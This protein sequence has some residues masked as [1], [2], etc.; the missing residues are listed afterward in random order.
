MTFRLVVLLAGAGTAAA[1][2]WPGWRGPAGMGH[3]AERALPLTWGGKD[4]ANVAW[5]VDLP[6]VAAKAGQDQNQSSPV[7]VGGKVFVTASYWP[8]GKADPKAFPEHHVACY[9][10]ADGKLLWDTKVPPGPWLL[11]DLRGGYTAPTPAADAER[12]YVVFGS[13]VVAAL[14]HAGRPVWRR[15]LTPH[16]FDVALAASPVL[17]DETLILQLDQ[18]GNESRLLALDRK[19]GEPRWEEKRPK[20]G[21]A[22]STPVVATVGGK[23]QLLVSASNAVQGVDPATGKVLWT[24][25]ARGDTVTPVLAG[26][27]VYADSGR[28]GPGLAVDPTGT[29]D[30]TKTHVKWKLPQVPE[31]YSSPVAVGEFLYRLHSPEVLRCVRAATGE[32]VFTERLPGV[33]TAC[34][35]VADAAGRVYCASAGKSYVL[36]AGPTP[37]VLAVNDLGDAGPASPAVADGALFLKG[38][39]WLVCVRAKD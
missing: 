30:V 27:L 21:F 4:G 37:E 17:F 22:H 15:E 13:A 14:D 7:V 39:R 5:K 23:Q 1:A 31:G 8:G 28:G 2:D 33:Q 16:K 10:A 36:K 6:G 29:G 26:G 20:I 38:R 25:D 3:T 24:C 11:S 12:V 19:T 18:L 9:A 32:V 35:P 34:S